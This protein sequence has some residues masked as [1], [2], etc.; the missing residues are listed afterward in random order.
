MSVGQ[1]TQMQEPL[2][3]EDENSCQSIVTECERKNKQMYNP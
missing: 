2:S 3:D 1:I